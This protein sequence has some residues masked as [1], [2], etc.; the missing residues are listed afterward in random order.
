MNLDI[1][2]RA[3]RQRH[4]LPNE[5]QFFRYECFPKCGNTIYVE[6][7]GGFPTLYKRGEKTGTPNWKK[8]PR[9]TC[10]TFVITIH[11]YET[12]IEPEYVAATGN[13][14]KCCGK[15]TELLSWSRTDG[16]KLQPC[17]KCNGTGKHTDQPAARC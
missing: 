13:C 14:P 1:A 4:N 9:D 6:I 5:F 12:A 17:R 3:L 7:E 16:T 2:D 10:R 8:M 15:G 11:E